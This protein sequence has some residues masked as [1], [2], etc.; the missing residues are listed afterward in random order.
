M[1]R[2]STLLR[3]GGVT[4]VELLISVVILSFVAIG[5]SRVL[6]S[7]WESHQALTAQNNVER[8]AWD[9]ID[10]IVDGLRSFQAVDL[11]PSPDTYLRVN[12][13]ETTYDANGN[14]KRGALAAWDRFQLVT[15]EI[16]HD[17]WR[18]PNT[19][20]S[21][22]LAG[23]VSALQFIL[24]QRNGSAMEETFDRNTAE[25]I[26]VSLTIEDDT[27]HGQK[28]YTATATSFA[29]LRNWPPPPP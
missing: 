27:W 15:D 3:T 11:N 9:A 29:K 25:M 24:Y 21:E 12:A 8:R 10:R 22:R 26:G 23:Q 4:L 19:Y 5:V 17:W 16:R 14:P 28:S 1:R 2:P 13:Y 6:I 18:A 20:K 7:S